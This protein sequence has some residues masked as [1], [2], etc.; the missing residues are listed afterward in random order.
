M[1]LVHQFL[2]VDQPG[3][4]AGGLR[5]GVAGHLLGHPPIRATLDRPLDAIGVEVAVIPDRAA[6]P[7]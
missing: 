5:L 2:R 3:P 4:G 6:L 1:L 7:K